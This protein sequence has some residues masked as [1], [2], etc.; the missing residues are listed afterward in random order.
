MGGGNARLEASVEHAAV[1][2]DI[3]LAVD[4]PEVAFTRIRDLGGTLEVGGET[5]TGPDELRA[6]IYSPC[7]EVSG[8]S[9]CSRRAPR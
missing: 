7:G 5:F 9:A 6:L 1:L 2:R 8:R 3:S 4:A